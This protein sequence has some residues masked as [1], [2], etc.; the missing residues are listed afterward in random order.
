MSGR[1]LDAPGRF[2]AIASA[3]AL[4][5]RMLVLLHPEMPV[6]DAL[7]HAHRLEY[8]LEGRAFFTS[9]APGNYSFPYPILLY[10]V[11]APLSF[12]T[13]TSAGHVV[14]L[15]AVVT[16]ADVLA[17]VA[18]YVMVVRAW[19]D[20]LAG[21]AALAIYH[22]FPL[23]ALTMTWGNLT[24]AFGQTLF[25][26]TTA[27]LASSRLRMDARR[28][29]LTLA[30]VM[31][32]AFLAH[33]STFG[34]LAGLAAFAWVLFCVRGRADEG[35]RS[36]ANAVLVATTAAGLVA[37]ALYYAHFLATYGLTFGRIGSE[38]ATTA[39]V[40]RWTDLSERLA[41]VPA[42]VVEYFAWPAVLLAALGL[43][44]LRAVARGDRLRLILA[45]WGAASLVFLILGLLTPINL[46]YYLALLPVVPMLAGLA[47]S[48]TWRGHP[49]WRIAL[50]VLAG[51]MIWAGVARHV[52]PLG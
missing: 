14:L 35:L 48:D 18:I 6:G 16:V 52:A 30:A 27:L 31:S 39:A 10:L 17:G 38:L 44:R 21:A 29:V 37:V 15:R 42:Q 12:L 8:V 45:A 24:N 7:F 49:R 46:R 43:V 9:L 41:A 36:A 22:L 25:V 40:S 32:A 51:W 20:R 5:L 19:N 1:R 26:G 3:A 2:V 4:F 50:V 33:P 34:I 47:W 23:A 11:A 28:R 13:S